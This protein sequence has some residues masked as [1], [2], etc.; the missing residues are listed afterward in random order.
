MADFIYV[1]RTTTWHAIGKDVSE[2]K[3]M[4]R[5]LKQSGLDYEVYKEPVCILDD[6]DRPDL[7]LRLRQSRQ[8]I[9]PV[10]SGHY[11]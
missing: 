1:D 9:Y 10:G 3:D 7:L 5:V 8:G 11:F 4:D 6:R 2:C